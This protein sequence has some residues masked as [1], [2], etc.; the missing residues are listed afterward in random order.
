VLNHV[1]RETDAL[2]DPTTGE[3]R[4]TYSLRHFFATLLIER[5][6]S[7]AKIAEWLGTSSAMVERHY[8]KYLVEREAHL[9]NGGNRSEDSSS[10]PPFDGSLLRWDPT[11]GEHGDWAPPSSKSSIW[12]S[13]ISRPSFN[14][15]VAPPRRPPSLP[16]QARDL[17]QSPHSV[18]HRRRSVPPIVHGAYLH[19][20]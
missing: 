4:V 14:R 7:V 16:F 12:F 5:N 19:H 13:V 15:T 3:K 18:I 11:I 2:I 20:R 8:G 17:K 1:L 10:T 6:L 9:L